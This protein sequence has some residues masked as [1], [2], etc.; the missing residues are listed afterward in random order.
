MTDFTNIKIPDLPTIQ[1]LSI[2]DNWHSVSCH[3]SIYQTLFDYY[4]GISNV[5][6]EGWLVTNW[7]RIEPE[8]IKRGK[9]AVVYYGKQFLLAEIIDLKRNFEQKISKFVI[10]FL[11]DNKIRNVCENLEQKQE[12]SNKK[13]PGDVDLKDVVIFRNNYFEKADFGGLSEKTKKIDVL[14][15]LIRHNLEMTKDILVIKTKTKLG[16]E[17][18]ESILGGLS[19]GKIVNIYYTDKRTK[20]PVDPSAYDYAIAG[21]GVE[22]RQQYW[23]DRDKIL[24]EIYQEYKIRHIETADKFSRTN[25][26]EVYSNL[27]LYWAWEKQRGQVRE[28]SIREFEEKFPEEGKCSLKYGFIFSTESSEESEEPIPMKNPKNETKSAED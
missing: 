17:Q 4:L 21:G 5:E 9:V 25:N 6:G 22:Q 8:L 24:E 3:Q 15:E 23:A 13:K 1:G 27:A 12:Q 10:R 7:W 20:Q 16:K 2:R 26:P 19:S 11:G 14:T 28:Q 18:E